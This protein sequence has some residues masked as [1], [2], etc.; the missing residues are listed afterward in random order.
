MADTKGQA[1][2]DG[3]TG[4]KQTDRL[5]IHKNRCPH[6]P[7]NKLR[8][9]CETCGATKAC[10]KCLIS[11]HKDHRVS[12]LS[13]KTVKLTQNGA[14]NH[15]SEYTETNLTAH[16]DDENQDELLQDLLKKADKMAEDMDERI[17]LFAKARA[18]LK[19]SS[20]MEIGKVRERGTRLKQQI[21]ELTTVLEKRLKDFR[22]TKEH[23]LKA[24][25]RSLRDDSRTLKSYCDACTSTQNESSDS[26][27]HLE[28]N[29]DIQHEIE[30]ILKKDNHIPLPVAIMD[31]FVPNT[32]SLDQIK[33][34]FG[35]IETQEKVDAP[36]KQN[37]GYI[38]PTYDHFEEISNF[39]FED[40]IIM[41]S[42]CPTNQGCAWI[43][44]EIHSMVYTNIQLVS[45]D[46][47]EES[48]NG[49]DAGVLDIATN[50][51]DLTLVS[52]T[53]NTV[54]RVLPNGQS[55]VRFETEAR[56]ESICFLSTN[57]IVMCFFKKKKVAVFNMKGRQ[58]L[59][60]KDARTEVEFIAHPFRVRSNRNNDNIAILNANP[61]SLVVVDR[62]L[63]LKFVYPENVQ[64][65][66]IIEQLVKPTQRVLPND[67]CFDQEN[68][69]LI[70]DAVCK[71]VVIINP[72]GVVLRTTSAGSDFPS[73]LALDMNGYLWVGYHNGDVKVIKY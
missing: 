42:L 48:S 26:G 13:S 30:H 23:M 59:S 55:I 20:V 22:K 60:S 39:Q 62:D 7:K 14:L 58:L 4:Q 11:M 67:V 44:R 40:E 29:I 21:D 10:R 1:W 12:D 61:Y 16:D 41:R 36:L 49:F 69:L 31:K 54:R 68:N 57:D 53:D 24:N 5:S 17:K 28:R 37:D 2:Q 45:I 38:V 64:R 65:R 51:D 9:V 34:V 50:L 66:G 6:H 15:K 27:L 70:C 52:C 73:S 35:E 56:P 43:V 46:G 3:R 33:S 32:T 25:E 71:C 63:S 72:N 19:H 8:F 18:D 47:D